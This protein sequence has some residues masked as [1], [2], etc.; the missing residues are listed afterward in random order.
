MWTVNEI[1]R[2][3]K[4]AFKG[5]Y[6]K[7][8]LVAFFLSVL[9]SGTTLSTGSSGTTNLAATLREI[10]N[11]ILPAVLAIA[12]LI[13]S[14]V[15]IISFLLK[16]FLFNPLGVGCHAF[17]RENVETT[18]ASLDSISLGFRNY[19]NIFITLFLRDL[20][21]VL[22]SLLFLIPGIVKSYSYR[23]VPYILSEDPGL[24]ATDAINRSREM[25]KGH[26]WK[27][28]LLDLSFFGWYVLGFITLGFLNYFWTEPYRQN[29]DAA[30]YLELRR[31]GTV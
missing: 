19:F 3:G 8:V 20:F 1:K 4:T 11:D 30:L 29:A 10:P 28:F 25:M 9:L 27:A 26:K 21:I 24:R 5:N 22:W 23:M 31:G 15:F 7:S 12:G 18:P 13:F 16:V 14:S 17:F 2:R 6:W